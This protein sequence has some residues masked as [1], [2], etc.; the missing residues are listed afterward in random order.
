[1]ELTA[2]SSSL[3]FE[4]YQASESS[5]TNASAKITNCGPDR[6]VLGIY[7]NGCPLEKLYQI[8]IKIKKNSIFLSMGGDT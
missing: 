2:T 4:T 5:I 6:K 8:C 7:Q 1:M 3:N